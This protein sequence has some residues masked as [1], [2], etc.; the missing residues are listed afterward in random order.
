MPREGGGWKDVPIS[1]E[2]PRI[3]G[4]QQELTKGRED[5]FSLGASGSMNLQPLDLRL[6]ATEAERIHACCFEPPHLWPLVLGYESTASICFKDQS[7][8]AMLSYV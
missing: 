3:G 4:K 1:Q 2:A 5:S 7:F 8:S 6:A